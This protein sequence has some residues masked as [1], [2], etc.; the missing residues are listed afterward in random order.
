MGPKEPLGAG[1]IKTPLER[2]AVLRLPEAWLLSQKRALV[3]VQ[4][5]KETLRI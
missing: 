5:G 3:L 2:G 1:S 4:V